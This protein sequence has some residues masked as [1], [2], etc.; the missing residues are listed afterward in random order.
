MA[1]GACTRWKMLPINDPRTGTDVQVYDCIDN[2][3]HDLRWCILRAIDQAAASTD[4]VA[5]EVKK[6]RDENVTMAAIA[7][8]RAN[9]AVR[10]ALRAEPD[11][12]LIESSDAIQHR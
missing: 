4:K 2:H 7:V 6:S 8:Q 1:S 10:E 3:A 5:T 12:L 11:Q 9:D